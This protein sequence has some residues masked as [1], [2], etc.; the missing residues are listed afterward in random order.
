M[1]LA[2]FLILLSASSGNCAAHGE[3]AILTAENA[4]APPGAVLLVMDGVGASYVYPEFQAY[5]ITGQPIPGIKLLNLT[6]RGARVLDLRVPVP[7]TSPAHS[8]L[9]TGQRDAD[10]ALVGTGS[11]VFDTLREE[12]FLCL[13]LLQRGDFQNMLEEQDGV[14]YFEDNSLCGDPTLG[15]RAD[16]PPS[17]QLML[18][19]W[20]NAFAAYAGSSYARYNRWGLDAAA[21]MVGRLDQ[22]FFLLVNIGGADSAAHARGADQYLETI[23]ALDAPL[24]RLMEAC[25][26]KGVLLGVTADHGMS[27]SNR[28]GH[29]SAQYAERLE[30]LRIPLVFVGDPAD[31]LI[32]DGI[33]SQTAVAPTLLRLLGIDDPR[34]PAD[35]AL[36]LSRLARL[37]VL[38]QGPQSIELNGTDLKAIKGSGSSAYRFEGLKR[39]TYTVKALDASHRV[40]VI[41]DQVLDLRRVDQ[42]SARQDGEP[43]VPRWMVGSALIVLINLAGLLVVW[44]VWRGG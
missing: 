8:V 1:I 19:Q 29:A 35:R 24:G 42:A 41:S 22:P 23:S 34:F 17:V 21:D 10:E 3:M 4:A 5:S 40:D 15:A 33:W 38:L 14:V 28:G 25:Q 12:G 27:F 32:L 16:L 6:S 20:R 39:G 26:E 2:L 44:R 11:T 30:S 31:D 9:V 43:F 36:P 37:T 13:A 7:S 18:Q